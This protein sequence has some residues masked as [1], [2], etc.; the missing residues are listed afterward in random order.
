MTV[1][2]PTAIRAGAVGE[3]ALFGFLGGLYVSLIGGKV[4]VAITAGGGD[5]V[6]ESRTYVY[7]VRL[8]GVGL[9]V[10]AI[11]TLRDGFRYLGCA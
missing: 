2:A 1:G 9:G 4:L 11:L 6:L 3:L 5:T 7:T 8:L 10:M